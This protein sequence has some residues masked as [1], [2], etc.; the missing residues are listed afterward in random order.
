MPNVE[1]SISNL[2]NFYSSYVNA[3]IESGSGVRS[4]G[5]IGHGI[6]EMLFSCSWPV[7]FQGYSRNKV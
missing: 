3:V 6:G 5:Y 7:S 4:N 1:E 2:R